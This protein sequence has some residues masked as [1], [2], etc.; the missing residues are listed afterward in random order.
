MI[1]NL[2]FVFVFFLEDNPECIL[3]RKVV[4]L[5]QHFRRGEIGVFVFA[6]FNVI[7]VA[8]QELTLKL[9]LEVVRNE[10]DVVLQNPERLSYGLSFLPR[11]VVLVG[12][13]AETSA[14]KV[15]LQFTTCL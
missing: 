11:I 7:V 15:L 13:I 4:Q 9:A 2:L 3:F 8:L 6:N 12:S 5:T 14:K 10:S 1:V